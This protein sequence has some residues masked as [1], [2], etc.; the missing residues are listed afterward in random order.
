MDF[1]YT[2]TMEMYK[3]IAKDF[4][5]RNIVPTAREYDKSREF[6]YE[7]LE[8]MGKEGFM[9]I[10]VSEEY[11]GLSLDPLTVAV[12]VEELARASAAIALIHQVHRV[13]INHLTNF[14]SDEQKQRF[15]PGLATGQHLGGFCFT[16]SQTA[17]DPMDF[18][19]FAERK[20]DH[21]VVNGAKAWVTNAVAGTVFVTFMRVAKEN[22]RNS[23]NNFLVEKEFPGFTVSPRYRTVGFCA[24]TTC[25]FK[26]KDMR[27][28]VE[29]RLGEEGEG[30]A[31]IGKT[32]HSGQAYLGVIGV[33]IGE[34]CLEEA[35]KY[36]KQ[37]VISGNPIIRYQLIAQKL[38]DMFIE[39][40]S[41]RILCHKAIWM[42][43]NGINPSLHSRAAKISAGEA[44]MNA[45]VESMA[46][47]GSA[48]YSD[49]YPVE[50]YFRDAKFISVG[51]VTAEIQRIN[52][53]RA[54]EKLY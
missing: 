31:H 29:N 28:P 41:A 20:D 49:E 48:G 17:S 46:I 27:V 11:G 53:G 43:E 40:E 8:K 5:D 15:L 45:G 19:C 36:A 35:A 51:L 54:I 21:Y 25:D 6:P 42:V 22:A 2:E 9:G 12:I 37:R 32:I 18:T 10:T 14:G 38:A 1:A 13:C 4:C 30:L 24:S 7:I 50:R 26:F 23:F 39:I 3:K 33:G 52:M 16:E 34:A 44:C 47:M